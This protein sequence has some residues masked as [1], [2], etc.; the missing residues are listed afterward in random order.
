MNQ[1]IDG[2][3]TLVKSGVI[4]HQVNCKGV[5]GAG[6]AL[7]IRNKFPGWY[8]NFVLTDLSLGEVGLYKIRDDL[9]IANLYAQQEF[10]GLDTGVYTSYLALRQSLDRLEG[11]SKTM[12]LPRP[13]YLPYGLGCGLGGGDWG[14]VSEEIVSKVCPKAIIVQYKKGQIPKGIES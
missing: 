5:A 1:M 2:D 4:G 10:Y 11:L 6:L 12:R 3:I 13:L 14:I 7:Q 8:D 9:W